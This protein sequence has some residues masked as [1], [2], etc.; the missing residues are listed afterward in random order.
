M[1]E[2]MTTP[3]GP[4]GNAGDDE[5]LAELRALA[6]GADPVPPSAIAAA[7]SAIAWRT[8]DAELAELTSDTSV[9]GQLAGIRSAATSVMLTFDALGLTVEIEVL[10][11]AGR[12]QVVGQLV[13]YGPG[14]VEVRS[15]TGA[16]TVPVDVVGRFSVDQVAPGP[17]SLRCRVGERVVETDWFLA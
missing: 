11:V 8:M 6:S 16:V 3:R 13:P 4:S 5:L 2:D 7:R 12:R 15:G 17:V 1:S 10:E 14:T 9:E